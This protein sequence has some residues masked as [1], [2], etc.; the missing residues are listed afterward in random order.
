MRDV[1]GRESVMSEPI[2]EIGGVPFEEAI[3]FLRDKIRLPKRRWTD[4]WEGQHARGFVI[5]GAVQ[6]PA[7]E[8]EANV[9]HQA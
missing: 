6:E 1:S 2:S 8:D 3:G 4:L 5:A 9:P 7:G